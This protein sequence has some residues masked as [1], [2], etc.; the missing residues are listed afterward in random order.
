MSNMHT[1]TAKHVVQQCNC[2][3]LADCTAI[4]LTKDSLLAADLHELEDIGQTLIKILMK[5]DQSAAHKYYPLVSNGQ[6]S[7]FSPLL[8][9]IAT[10]S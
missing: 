1:N 2:Q 8:L 5:E 9:G 3:Q 6:D 10:L 4:L 7:L